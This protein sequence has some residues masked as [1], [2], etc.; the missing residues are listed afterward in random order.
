VIKALRQI[1]D[2][3]AS[4][5]NGEDKAG[6]DRDLIHFH[7]DKIV[8][9]SDRIEI[10]ARNIGRDPAAPIILPWSPAPASPRREI[11]LPAGSDRADPRPIR[12]ESRAR[13]L[14]AIAKARLWVDELVAGRTRDTNEI[15][16]REG[17]SERSVRMTLSLAFL[18]P[19]IVQA[20]VDGTPARGHG[21]S[22]LLEL[23]VDCQ[24]QMSILAPPR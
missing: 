5:T 24:K 7:L 22:T 6:T 8:V 2:G 20:A 3:G 23:P 11:T 17:Y 16:Q 19:T 14:E 21:V 4:S 1:T 12:A 13:L 15:A 9:R 18:S 10:T